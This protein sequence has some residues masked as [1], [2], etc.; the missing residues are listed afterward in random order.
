MCLQTALV[1]TN[2]GI[3]WTKKSIKYNLKKK[4]KNTIAYAYTGGLD[5]IKKMKAG[6]GFHFPMKLIK[7]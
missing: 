2:R 7:H 6:E 1:R 4:F 5:V 3:A